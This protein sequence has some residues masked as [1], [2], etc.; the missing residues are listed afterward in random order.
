MGQDVELWRRELGEAGWTALRHN[1]WKA[2][3]GCLYLGPYRAWTVM[4]IYK[5]NEILECPNTH[6]GEV[7]R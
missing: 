4:H 7:A 5:A 1:L 2:P 6:S 3:C